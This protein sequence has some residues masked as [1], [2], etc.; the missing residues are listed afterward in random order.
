MD[1]GGQYNYQAYY[2]YFSYKFLRLNNFDKNNTSII[3][4]RGIKGNPIYNIGKRV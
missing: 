3:G 4:D 1:K 2:R